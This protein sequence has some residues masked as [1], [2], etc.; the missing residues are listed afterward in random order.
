MSTKNILIMKK[1]LALTALFAFLGTASFAAPNHQSKKKHHK[2]HKH[3]KHMDKKDDK[4]TK[5]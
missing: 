1:I 5:M 2:H 4:K 3:H